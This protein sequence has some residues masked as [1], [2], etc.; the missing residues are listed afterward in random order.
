MRRRVVIT[1][2]GVVAPSGR[3]VDDF[4]EAL[5]AGRSGISRVSVFEYVILPA[6][7]FWTAI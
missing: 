2:M 5:L 6:S 7:A 1:G 3:T 4:H